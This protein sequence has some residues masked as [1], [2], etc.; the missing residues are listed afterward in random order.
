M[1]FK[2]NKKETYT[3]EDLDAILEQHTGFV[4]KDFKDFVSPED[5]K[6]VVDEL[7]PFKEEANNKRMSGLMPDNAHPA[8]IND[9]IALSGVNPEDDDEAIK[10][11]LSKTIADRPHLQKPET[12]DGDVAKPKVEGKPDP[13]PQKPEKEDKLKEMEDY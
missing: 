5:Y 3:Q 13:I 12:Q 6:Q 11:K 8:A 10:E 4:A 7:A 2:Y 9:I 1:D